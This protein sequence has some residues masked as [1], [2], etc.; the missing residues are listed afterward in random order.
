MM[1]KK[2]II[3]TLDVIIALFMALGIVA[4]AFTYLEETSHS[5]N[6]NVYVLSLDSLGMLEKDYTLQR[7][8]QQNSAVLLQQFVNTLPAPLCGNISIYSGEQQKQWSVQAN[9]CT[10]GNDLALARRAFAVNATL[11]YA[12]MRTWFQ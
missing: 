7:A 3:Y 10:Q 12:E 5:F 4:F 9:N 6:N 11:Y 8:V 1:P 2:G